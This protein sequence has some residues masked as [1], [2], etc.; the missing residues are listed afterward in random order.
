M[1]ILPMSLY[2]NEFLYVSRVN[3]HYFYHIKCSFWLAAVAHTCN[4]SYSGGRDQKDAVRGQCRQKVCETP[5]QSM[6]GQGA[7]CLSSQLYQEAQIGESR[8]RQPWHKVR[9]YL[10]N[11]QH[12]KGWWIVSSRRALA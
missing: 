12:K 1:V 3:M 2:F 11:N 7:V 10:K 5:S 4:P 6:L 9:A 8:S